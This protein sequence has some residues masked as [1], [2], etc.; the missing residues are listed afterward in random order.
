M[1]H[2][3]LPIAI[4]SLCLFSACQTDD[5][6][7]PSGQQAQAVNDPLLLESGASNASNISL[8]KCASHRLLKQKIKNNPGWAKKLEMIEAQTKNHIAREKIKKKKGKKTPA[9]QESLTLN[10]PVYVHIVYNSEQE[11]IS[12]QQI[13]S[14]IA[15]LNADYAG[16]NSEIKANKV[17]SEF[18]SLVANTGISFSWNTSHIVRK[19]SSRTYWSTTD[20]VK[21]ANRGGSD[22]Y[23]PAEYLNIWIC[24]IGGGDLAY[25]Q[26]PGGA[27]ASDGIVISPQFVG[28][29]GYLQAPFN[30]GRTLTH[31]IGHWLNLKHIWGDG[32]C[33]ADDGVAD[34]P[35]S[36]RPNYGC[37]AYPTLHCSANN[38][39]M[40]FMDYSDDAC[41]YMFTPGQ[42]SRMHA[43]FSESG[44]R[45]GFA[46]AMRQ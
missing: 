7:P 46:K 14:Q 11:N 33:S 29:T 20:D 22:A 27:P 21:F 44:A 13:Q 40:N 12:V 41:M 9:I 19:K 8:R 3:L 18:K 10:I 38:M 35:P 6:E 24:N 5:L 32:D 1:K 34:T 25:A 28:T 39:S 17:P 36:D 43:L 2:I 42:R 30:K 15:V 31:E 23:R 26:F 16:V 4:A 37:P 45:A